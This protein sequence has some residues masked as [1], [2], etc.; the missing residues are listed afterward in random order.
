YYR[1]VET[2]FNGHSLQSGIISVDVPDGVISGLYIE[3]NPAIEK[4]KIGF[5]A[6]TAGVSTIRILDYTGREISSTT[7]DANQGLNGYDFSIAELR[8][9]FY[10]IQ[11]S[12]GRQV[13]NGKLLK[14]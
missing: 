6:N 11:V 2:D 4:V 1:L 12:A 8:Q 9:G 5:N 14:E 7:V 13:L 10:F 3:P